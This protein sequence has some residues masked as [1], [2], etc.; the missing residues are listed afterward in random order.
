MARLILL[1]RDGVINAE[2]GDFVKDASEWHPLPGALDAI[3]RLKH[4]GCLVAVCS[5]QSGIGRGLMSPAAVD[6]IHAQLH[7]ELAR[8]GAALD[9]LR[10]CPHHPDDGCACRKP[11]P[12]MLLETLSA[13]GVVAGDAIFVGDSLRDQQ[14]AGAAGC[15]F[16]LVR[17]GNGA[18]LAARRPAS[19]SVWVGDDLAGFV[20]WLLGTPAC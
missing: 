10:I 14:A 8:R 11:R 12:G 7:R 17:T 5:N 1:D 15:A 18:A 13:C 16:A 6:S 9:G 19:N 4:A 2:S 3:A 20:D